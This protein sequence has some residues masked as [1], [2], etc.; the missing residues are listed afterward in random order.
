MRIVNLSLLN[1]DWYVEQMKR[2]AY[3]SAPVPIRM[4]E[5][6]YRQ[7]TRDIVLMD[8]PKDP[9]NPYVDIEAAMQVALDDGDQVDY[10]VVASMRTCRPTASAC[11]WTAPLR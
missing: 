8:P 7:G 10:G 6:Q 4:G 5:E 1:T 9:N 2:R 11:R 3:D